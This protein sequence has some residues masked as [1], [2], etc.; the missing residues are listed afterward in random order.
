MSREWLT[1]LLR[2]MDGAASV[3]RLA[4]SM[5]PRRGHF[6]ATITLHDGHGFGAYARL[7]PCVAAPSTTAEDL[8]TTP[9]PQPV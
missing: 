6:D 7:S 8:L 5:F 9:L 3:Y 4:T 1:L 2:R